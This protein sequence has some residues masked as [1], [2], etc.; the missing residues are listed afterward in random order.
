MLV[1]KGNTLLVFIVGLDNCDIL[2][3]GNN[4]TNIRLL[5]GNSIAFQCIY[6]NGAAV[7]WKLNGD[8]V[9]DDSR[10]IINNGTL[11]ILAV[12]SSDNGNY[13]C[14]DCHLNLIVNGK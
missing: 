9:T 11:T 7:E 4:I 14:G 3:N 12:R 1:G 6:D 5:V 10:H 13:S 8:N 2:L